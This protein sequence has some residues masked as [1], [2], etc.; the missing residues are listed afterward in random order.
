VEELKA[1]SE[2]IKNDGIEGLDGE[3]VR[4]LREMLEEVERN[5]NIVA[6]K[7]AEAKKAKKGGK[8]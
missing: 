6:E 7:Q 8:K 3:V 1:V 4:Q 2:E 5:P